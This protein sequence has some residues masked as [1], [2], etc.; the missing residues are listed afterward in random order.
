MQFIA[1]TIAVS[2][3]VYILWRTWESPEEPAEKEN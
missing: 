3:I 1:I 2:I